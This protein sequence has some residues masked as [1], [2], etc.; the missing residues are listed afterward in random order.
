MNECKLV[1]M[2]H[3]YFPKGKIPKILFICKGKRKPKGWKDSSVSF[4]S[5]EE[6]KSRNQTAIAKKKLRV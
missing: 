6:E 2:E 5:A 4:E 3:F 1:A